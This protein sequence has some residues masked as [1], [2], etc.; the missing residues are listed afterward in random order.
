MA[1]ALVLFCAAMAGLSGFLFGYDSG[2]MTTTIA[3]QHFLQQ[4]RPSAAMIGTIIAMM[5]VGGFFGCLVA[6]KV[7]DSWGR[8]RAIA[9]G[10]VFT[11][12]C[13][14]SIILFAFLD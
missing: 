9:F 1:L 3:Q 6:G 13:G 11:L 14:N 5:Q 7:S 2:V 10:C 4:F 8:K 12:V